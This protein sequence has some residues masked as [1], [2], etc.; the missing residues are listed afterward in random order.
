MGTDPQTVQTVQTIPAVHREG[1]RATVG[2]ALDDV[3]SWLAR[4]VLADGADLDLLTLWAAHTHVCRE[5]Y[6]TPRL[7]ID[8]PMPGSGKT[9]VLEHLQRF[10][11]KPL[12][13]ASLSSAALLARMLVKDVRTILIDEADRSLDPDNPN[14]KEL[15]AILNS[16]YKRGATR[17]VLVPGKGGEW[18][19]A[20][21]TTFAPVAIAGNAPQLPDDTRSRCVRVLLMPDL[22]GVVEATDW[23]EFEPDAID[24]AEQ[25]ATAMSDAAEFIRTIRPPLPDG[26][27]GRLR[28][29][30]SPLA[31]TAAAAG[32]RWPVAVTELAERDIEEQ[33][34]D[35]EDGLLRR[36]P[37]VVLL[38]DLHTVWAESDIFKPTKQLVGA[39]IE[40]NPAMWGAGSGYGRELT[41]QRFGRMLVQSTKIHSRKNHEDKRGYLRAD[42]SRVWRQLGITPPLGTAG[43]V[44][45]VETVGTPHDAPGA[46]PV[47]VD[48]PP[49]DPEPCR[50][51]GEPLHRLSVEAGICASCPEL[52]AGQ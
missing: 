13:A 20:E 2:N 9:T 1:S 8:S 29:K 4:F 28:E 18:D 11:Y 41:V 32:G 50:S 15:L 52:A 31:R 21:M 45:T 12:Q 30:W 37:A 22:H 26:C 47:Q 5:T 38:D 17:P 3:R 16:G 24:L 7:I 48:P 27:V 14:T 43:T 39:V 10:A 19:V 34:M 33:K 46:H 25:L 49:A 40:V 36:P 42:F 51:C 44:A 23:E 6:T 35:R